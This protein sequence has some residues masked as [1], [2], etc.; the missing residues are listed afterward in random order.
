MSSLLIVSI[1]FELE[2]F[3]GRNF[4]EVTLPCLPVPLSIAPCISLKRRLEHIQFSRTSRFT[5]NLLQNFLPYS[6]VDDSDSA[7]EHTVDGTM[8]G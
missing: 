2:I 3:C 4:G 5:D 7:F 6:F 8:I 1:K